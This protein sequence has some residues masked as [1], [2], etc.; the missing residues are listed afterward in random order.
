[1]RQDFRI[2]QPVTATED[3]PEA[4]FGEPSEEIPF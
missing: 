1:M 2:M 4:E 3:C